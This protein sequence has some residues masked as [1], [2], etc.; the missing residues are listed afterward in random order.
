MGARRADKGC[1]RRPSYLFWGSMEY[2]R[3]TREGLR[4]LDHMITVQPITSA[5]LRISLLLV[6]ASS[7]CRS[8]AASNAPPPVTG[9]G[10]RITPSVVEI[11][12]GEKQTL[13]ADVFD[14]NGQAVVSAPIQWVTSDAS[15]ATV[16]A[17]GEVTGMAVG[18]AR[19]IASSLGTADTADVR[20][21]PAAPTG[22]F[23]DV[24]PEVTFQTM[25][26]WEATAQMGEAECNPQ[27]F[28]LYKQEILNRAVNELGIDRVRLH[29]RS[30]HESPVDHYATFKSSHQLS[31]WN[32]YRYASVNDNDDPRSIRAGGFQ[33]TEL[34]HKVAEIITPLRALLQARGEQLYVNLNYVDFGVSPWE[35]SSNPEEYAELILAVFQHL[36]SRYGWVPD[37][38][39][40]VLEPDNTQNWTPQAIGAALVATGDRLKAAGFR[41]AFIAPSN[42]GMIG[43]LNYLNAMVAV[44]RVSEYLTD[45]AYHR[46]SSAS[47]T[48]LSSIAARANQLGLRTAM[49][50]HIGSGYEDLHE[51]LT[52][53]NNSSWSQFVLAYC[54]PDNGGNY[55]LIDQSVPSAPKVSIGNRSRY[56]RQYF[57][58]VRLNARRL[59]AVSGDARLNPVAFRNTNGKVV[60]VIAATGA[61]PVQLRRLPAGTYGVTFT[62]AS[63]TFVSQADVVVGSSGILQTSMPATGVMTIHAR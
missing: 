37:A 61:A 25:L 63:Q 53:G 48:T 41:P 59:G 33:F 14:E 1:L 32:P 62:T 22:A 28:P 46:Y 31:D 7:S 57:A 19:I 60:V 21:T 38:V 43:A 44:P 26:G 58:F 29:V 3:V 45:V 36:Q 20:V 27:S 56:L 8:D 23:V 50:E 10:V 52:I 5:V 24:Y 30:G 6:L 34:D 42:T 54:A 15:V 4:Y 39:E 35:Q 9:A 47:A 11:A 18:D 49:L 17:S 12:V 40:M 13:R 51:D 2:G 55:Y 16:S